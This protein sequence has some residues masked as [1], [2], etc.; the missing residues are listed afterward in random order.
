MTNPGEQPVP[1]DVLEQENQF[2][3]WHDVYETSSAVH[4]VHPGRSVAIMGLATVAAS[5]LAFAAQKSPYGFEYTH[6]Y[7]TVDE[8][9][10]RTYDYDRDIET[11]YATEEVE[12]PII[13]TDTLPVA[14]VANLPDVP[15]FALG[16][17]PEAQRLL[18][19]PAIDALITESQA[20]IA[21]DWTLSQVAVTGTSSDETRMDDAAGLGT[22]DVRNQQLAA[23]YGQFIGQEVTGRLEA[24]GVA[25][26]E[27]IQI[28]A[29]E[30]LLTE[31]QREQVAAIRTRAGLATDRDLMQLYKTDPARLPEADRAL[32]ATY[33]DANRGGT[34]EL[35]FTKES[36]GTEAV[37]VTVITERCVI[38]NT[39]TDTTHEESTD[40]AF[41]V[42]FM[43]IPWISRRRI[44]KEPE[45]TENPDVPSP[46]PIVIGE[47]TETEQWGIL[48]PFPA[49]GGEET[50]GEE[51]DESPGEVIE[52][53]QPA[54]GEAADQPERTIEDD[55]RIY[56]GK[57]TGRGQ[58][59]FKTAGLRHMQTH[60]GINKRRREL[61]LE[62]NP[63]VQGQLDA[64][65]ARLGFGDSAGLQVYVDRELA[66]RNRARRRLG[67]VGLV[68]G[69]GLIASI[70]V[71]AGYCPDTSEHADQDFRWNDIPDSLSFRLQ[72][73]FTDI[74][75]DQGT[76]ILDTCIDPTPSGTPGEG[77][78][79]SAPEAEPICD[80][81][82]V[83]IRDGVVIDTRET[84]F[85]GAITTR[86]VTP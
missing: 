24:A 14:G 47:S 45:P 44:A 69:A 35:T 64:L 23:E 78:P 13:N 46:I 17:T 7:T 57:V 5:S 51:P 65:G 68:L 8:T 82:S 56:G 49:R 15:S 38:T 80:L 62:E 26:P 85:P 39:I 25:V 84:H 74:E 27:E 33:L 61:D 76:I 32:L 18:N 37:P 16:E 6:E 48:Y 20:K 34:I 72:V 54:E 12:R 58:I 22:P 70:D 75:T 71:D 11:T 52:L 36:E 50:S 28:S 83:Y 9:V 73:P 43:P 29:A 19:S 1:Q 30:A 79:P 86:T 2:L 67:G 41:I 40:H 10:E 81:R 4:Q 3:R 53:K 55:L 66:V 31:D 42:P 21:D 60:L 59:K 63:T 77:T